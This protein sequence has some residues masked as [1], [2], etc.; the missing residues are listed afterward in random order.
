M[1]V[2]APP[3]YGK[4]TFT[5]QWCR[6]DPRPTAWLG[7]READNDP[8]HL[9]SRVMAAL[10]AIESVDPLFA[11]DLSQP[12]PNLDRAIIRLL[13]SWERRAPV[14]V[15]FDE[16]HLLR[17]SSAI[18]V[19]R[20]LAEA[21]PGGSQVILL[22]RTDPPF[23]L[24]RIRIAGDLYEVRV[25]ALAL[26][27]S[28]TDQLLQ[29]A[30]VAAG[31]DDVDRLWQQ[32]EGWAAV[33]SLAAMSGRGAQRRESLASVS[34]TQRDIADYLWEEVLSHEQ[35]DVRRFLLVTSLT[36]R[37]CGELCDAMM[38]RKDSDRVLRDLASV[39]LFIVPLDEHRRWYRYH[40]LFQELLQ[41]EVLRSLEDPMSY[42][43]RAAAW[44]EAHG[45]PAEAFEYS[46]RCGDMVRAGRVLMRHWDSY[47]GRGRIETLLLWLEGCEDRDIESD[48]QFAI[49]AAWVTALAGDLARAYRYLA[50]AQRGDLDHPSPDGA[51]TLRAAML[52]LRAALA[53]SGV[54]QMLED[55]LAVIKSERTTRSRW[56]VGGY[57]TVGIAYLMLGKSKA[58]VTALHETLLLT[59]GRP[60]LL[61]VRVFCLGMLALAHADLDQWALAE[62][63]LR[64]GES[65]LARYDDV[66]QGLPIL[67]MRS[68]LDARNGDRGGTLAAI[69][70]VRAVVPAG[71][72]PSCLGAELTL[73]CAQAAHLVGADDLARE[74]VELSQ[75]AAGRAG[76]AG[77]VVQRLNDLIA[78]MTGA[79]TRVRQLTPAE[80]RV[81][82]QLAT[83]RT[84]KQIAEH[85][86]VSRATVKTH[87]GS[88]YAKLGVTSRAEAVALL[89]NKD[90]KVE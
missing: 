39:N 3:G 25:E 40:H 9:L 81:L 26:D 43:D 16:V 29:Q 71:W 90:A 46:R 20:S 38:D 56:L 47:A 72:G 85:L 4:T 84:L 23:G 79:D 58:A 10:E 69:A 50:A 57:R 78:D 87:V 32:A 61:H 55:G 51:T 83:H 12:S 62:R 68:S 66:V 82:R 34:G 37:L 1:L 35:E 80:M 2:Q 18:Q 41:A 63:Y 52:N 73:R 86:Y 70:K 31:V 22:T 14:Q 48:P 36:Q 89:P 53:P 19:L 88:I 15:V 54:G 77:T 67:L 60:N 7:L 49:G 30:G 5:A 59:E 75:L 33:I 65:N 64:E 13:K 76:D 74:F 17:R 44:H 24:A 8:I 45:E 42:L 28:E 11:E 21:A 6:H 27:R